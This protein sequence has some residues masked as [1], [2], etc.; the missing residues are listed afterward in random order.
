ME[1]IINDRIR[2]RKA[3][4]FNSF[5]LSLKYN[6]LASTFSFDFFYDPDVLEQKEMACIGHYHICKVIHNE[7][8]MLTGYILSEAFSDSAKKHLVAIGGYSL[9]GVLE[10]CQVPTNEAVLK[11]IASGRLKSGGVNLPFSYPLQDN[12]LTLL[13]IAEKYVSPFG[14]KVLVDPLVAAVVSIPLI[15]ETTIKPTDTIKS[16]LTDLAL[17]RN[18]NLTHDRFG[19][20]YFTQAKTDLLPKLDFNV[21]K[22]GLPGVQMEMHFDGQS[23]HSHITAIRQAELD[24]LNAGEAT[25]SNPYVPFVF[26]PKTFVVNSGDN[27]TVQ[28]A[29]ENARADELRGLQLTISIDRWDVNGI[30]LFPNNTVTVKNPD[31]YLFKKTKFFIEAID[32]SGDEKSM[33]AVLHCV[34]PE[35]YNG[36][37]PSYIFQ[38]INLH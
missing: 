36:K 37:E 12:N 20:L 22:G 35:V 28:K 11:A 16:Y 32:Y 14:L 10:D 23:M 24:T 3:T 30:V 34:L 25:V 38:G 7:Q 8:L 5:N 2:Q 6:T 29:A 33:K 26:R 17:C 18:V 31:I 27:N 4:F 19:N 15:T 21:P 9:P 13:Q 1:L